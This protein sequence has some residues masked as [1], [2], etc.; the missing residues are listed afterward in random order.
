[1]RRFEIYYHNGTIIRGG[2]NDD[3]YVSIRVP[4]S[5]IEAPPD[6]VQAIVVEDEERGCALLRERDFYMIGSKDSPFNGAIMQT[7]DLGPYLRE[8]GLVKY[9]LWMDSRKFQEL[10]NRL[11][12]SDFYKELKEGEF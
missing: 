9:G 5:W 4:K 10:K 3:E 12:E 7:K 11:G 1:M 8:M 6:G 2:G